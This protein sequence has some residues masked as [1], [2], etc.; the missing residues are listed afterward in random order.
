MKCASRESDFFTRPVSNLVK[1][2]CCDYYVVGKQG[3]F[4][5]PGN[6]GNF[7]NLNSGIG[8][9][10]LR[11]GS[12][13]K[14]IHVFKC[15]QSHKK[16][17]IYGTIHANDNNNKKLLKNINIER[18]RS[19]KRLVVIFALLA[20]FLLPQMG[21]AYTY[22]VDPVG[23]GGAISGYGPYQTGSGGE[24]TLLN[25]DG[26]LNTSFINGTYSLLTQDVFQSGTFQTFCVEES[27]TIGTGLY[28]GVL[29]T[30]AVAGGGGAVGGGDP[31]SIGAAYLYYKFA[32]GTL[33]GYNYAASNPTEIAARKTTAGQLQ[34]AIWW[35]EQE[36]PIYDESNPFMLAVFTQFGSEAGARANN[37]VYPVSVLNLYAN[38]TLT[39]R[40]QDVLVVTTPIPGALWLLG[41]GLLG[42]VAVR[43][44]RK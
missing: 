36:G 33:T 37:S 16:K 6:D 28:Y 4:C 8:N 3:L 42:L 38:S 20:A 44:R 32:T 11:N 2:N 19:M 30:Q 39:T 14:S 31:L 5:R 13:M 15:L 9:R 41:S 17:C 23:T 29:N 25:V 26:A 12:S 24:F 35:L 22:T 18:G 40:A 34:N 21:A 43:R 7:Y 10:S 27:E 1:V